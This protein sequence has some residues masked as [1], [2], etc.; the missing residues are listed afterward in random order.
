MSYNVKGGKLVKN[1]TPE[2]LVFHLPGEEPKRTANE[3]LLNLTY[4][5]HKF[6]ASIPGP[7]YL[8]LMIE[9]FREIIATMN[10]RHETRAA[11]LDWLIGRYDIPERAAAMAA[12]AVWLIYTSPD[13]EVQRLKQQ[14]KYLAYDITDMPDG[15]KNW[16]LILAGDEV[17]A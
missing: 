13:S 17:A 10:E 6:C 1:G 2:L 9:D 16:R 5:D 11:L 8:D 14:A 3:I 4:G 15:D 12:A 7:E